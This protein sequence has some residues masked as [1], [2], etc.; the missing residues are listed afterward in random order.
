MI[1]AV[2]TNIFI[3]LWDS[4]DSMNS[5][6]LNAL[7]R[8]ISSGNLVVCGAVYAELLALPGRT[9]KFLDTFF[10]DTGVSIDWSTEK[11]IWNAAGLAFQSYVKRRRSQRQPDARRILADFII[12]A[13]ADVNG[14]AFMTLD[15]RIYSAA[16]P[17]LKIIEV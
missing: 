1:T 8:G 5:L 4:D 11:S 6:A 16:F 10:H 17:N 7:D 14:F 12:G 13:H 9:P 15:K 3:A 2:D